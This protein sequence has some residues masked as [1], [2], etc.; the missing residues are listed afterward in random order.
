MVLEAISQADV[1]EFQTIP[2]R[3]LRGRCLQTPARQHL[4]E[5]FGGGTGFEP[6]IPAV[7]KQEIEG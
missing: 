7:S 5:C 2:D 6:V 1:E 3:A 4:N